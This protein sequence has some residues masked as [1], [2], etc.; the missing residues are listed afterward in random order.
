MKKVGLDYDPL[1]VVLR[2]F[3]NKTVVAKAGDRIL[4]SSK[5]YGIG[6]CYSTYSSWRSTTLK[7]NIEMFRAILNQLRVNRGCI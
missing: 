7:Y 5:G 2:L 4:R 6:F 1:I 3:T